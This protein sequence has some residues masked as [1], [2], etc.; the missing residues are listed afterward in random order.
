[1]QRK[2]NRAAAFSSIRVEVSAVLSFSILCSIKRELTNAARSATAEFVC[3]TT[4]EESS[5]QET[6]LC[7][8]QRFNR[9]LD[10]CIAK[11][12]GQDLDLHHC[13]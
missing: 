8:G 5:L 9:A 3:H 1:M 6:L 13:I 11:L 10:N 4:V 2:E 7:C 12:F